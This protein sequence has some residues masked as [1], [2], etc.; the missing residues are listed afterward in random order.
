LTTGHPYQFRCIAEIRAS[1]KISAPRTAVW[2]VLTDPSR[3]GEW[4]TIHDGFK[5]SPPSSVEAGSRFTQKLVVAGKDF[6]VEW[7][8]SEVAEP[9]LL[10]WDAKGPAGSTARIRCELHGD[11]ETNFT[12]VSEF[13]PPGGKVGDAAASVVEGRA[14]DEAQATL[15]RL[16]RLVES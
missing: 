6:E 4:V 12:Y 3:L 15:V 9:E 13:D 2:D 11:G 5:G 10:E 1:I 8:A 14:D 7:T 16:K